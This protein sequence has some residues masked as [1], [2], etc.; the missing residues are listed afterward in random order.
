MKFLDPKPNQNYI[1]CTLGGAGY[2][3]A[4][5]KKIASSSIKY[6]EQDNPIGKIISIDLDHEAIVNA[7]EL[8]K[9]FH[10]H[11]IVFAN[12]N[13]K[14][15]SKIVKEYFK[16]N[17]KFAGIVFD[18]GL[19][20]AQ[21]Q[22]RHRGFSFNLAAP[23]NM[24][25]AQ[26]EKQFNK[27][28]HLI[29]S[30][31]KDKLEKIIS[32]YGE[33][34]FAKSI[35]LNIVKYRRKHKIKTTDQLVGII[36]DSIPKKYRFGRIH[37]ATRTFQALRIATND[38]LNNLALALPQALNLLKKGGKLIVISYHSL[39]DRIVKIFFHQEAKD[40]L[41]PHIYPV[42]QCKHLAQLKIITHHVVRPSLAEIES[43]PRSRSAKLRVAE[44]IS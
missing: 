4:I 12:D 32:Q 16:P 6:N 14:N 26:P 44:K 1:D 29:N 11:N 19:S 33:E 30:L 23:L 3:L 43:N 24:D 34:K 31:N 36:I 28:E 15:L 42:C 20:S 18:L 35:A 22:D 39:E 41:C 38:E 25:F 17:E 27:T 37:P 40:C 10:Y 5:A 9:K 2:T 7:Q 13:F 8:I 21:L